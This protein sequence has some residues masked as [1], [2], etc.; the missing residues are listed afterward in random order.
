MGR[1][2]LL[3][4]LVLA[5]WLAG[6]AFGGAARESRHTVKPGDN[7][8]RIALRYGV[9]V[10]DLMRANGI[11]DPTQL[12]VGRTLRIP[13]ESERREGLARSGGGNACTPPEDVKRGA[14]ERA[15]EEADVAFGW[16]L[17]G[18]LSTCYGERHS[19]PH[20]GIDI[21]TPPGTPVRAAEAGKVIFS[22]SM[23]AYGRLVILKHEG[24]YASVYAHN[25]ENLVE[26]GAFVE[27]GDVIAESGAT[28]N[29]TGPH[30][31]FEIRRLERP[32]DP[33]LY[34]P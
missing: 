21:A 25:D 2:G 33:M 30:L 13:G 6:C 12:E 19:R 1:L 20:E 3:A 14:Q 31:H 15:R 22:G 23:G 10:D 7:L 9:S 32:D 11:S 34:L 16:P 4:A 29:A 24:S 28:G 17:R 26:K 5:A 8:Y 18:R 27:K